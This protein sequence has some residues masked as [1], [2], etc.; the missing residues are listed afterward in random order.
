M[1]TLTAIWANTRIP[2]QREMTRVKKEEKLYKEWRTVCKH[3]ERTDD[4]DNYK[5]GLDKLFDI[6]KSDA[7]ALMEC[8]MNQAKSE[9]VKRA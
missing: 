5:S 6:S 2:L 4:V 1:G 9:D 8:S 7:L 3:P